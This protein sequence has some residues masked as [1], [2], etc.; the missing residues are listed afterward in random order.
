MKKYNAFII[1]AGLT[2]FCMIMLFACKKDNGDIKYSQRPASNNL[3]LS[4]SGTGNLNRTQNF[5]TL[6]TT[7][8]TAAVGLNLTKAAGADITASIGVDTNKVANYNAVN[9]TQFRLLPATY[10]DLQAPGNG[11]TIKAGNLFSTDSVKVNFKN[12]KG[13]RASNYLLPVTILSVSGDKS[14]ILS[15]SVRTVYIN[16]TLSDVKQPVATLTTTSG[17]LVSLTYPVGAKGAAAVTPITINVSPTSPNNLTIGVATDNTKIASYGSGFTAFPDGSY[18]LS[19]TTLNLGSGQSASFNVNIPDLSK[20]D[21]TKSYL[22]PLMITKI[23]GDEY[24]LNANKIVYVQLS[25]NNLNNTNNTSAAGSK[26]LNRQGWLA[27]ATA[28]FD[29]SFYGG[30]NYVPA[31]AIDGDNST[32][33]V[34]NYQTGTES[35]TID[36]GASH[37]VKTIAYSNAFNSILSQFS[38]EDYPSSVKVYTS[39]NGTDWTSQGTYQPVANTGGS[40]AAPVNN[41]INFFNPINARY[42]RLQVG[43]YKSFTEINVYE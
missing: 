26:L 18:S 35:I 19:A 3:F 36:M 33:W 16:L 14:A 38:I 28:S 42:V 37:Q 31:N 13:L 9:G 23:N 22:L 12:L 6:S 25:F 20:F 2:A 7:G 17:N 34:S 21:G 1:A 32:D 30:S 15:D 29:G 10:Y 11:V 39:T 24:V 4:I 27:N 43:Y 5:T 8:G 40:A 41:Y